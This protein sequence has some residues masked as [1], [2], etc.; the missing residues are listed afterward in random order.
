[1]D[2][3]RLQE[4]LDEL[5]DIQDILYALKVEARVYKAEQ[6]SNGYYRVP[7]VGGLICDGF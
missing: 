2:T 5:M 7:V 6:D 3:I 4:N 1:M